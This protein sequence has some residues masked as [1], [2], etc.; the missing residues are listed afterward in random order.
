M[1]RGGWGDRGGGDG[2]KDNCAVYCSVHCVLLSTHPPILC[3]MYGYVQVNS[4]WEG[5]G[6]GTRCV[7]IY[8]SA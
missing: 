4:G 1:A 6:A 2:F 3:Y 7:C 8:L 5:L